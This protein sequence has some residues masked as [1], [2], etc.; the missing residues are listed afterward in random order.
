MHAL[1]V[2]QN[3]LGGQVLTPWERAFIVGCSRF[4]RHSPLSEK[5]RAALHSVIRNVANRACCA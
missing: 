3:M 2:L 1:T 5:Q 4:V